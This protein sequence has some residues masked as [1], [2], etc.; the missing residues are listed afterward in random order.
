[1]EIQL[2]GQKLRV[3]VI[4][5][6]IVL[7]YIIGGHIL[8][9]CSK[10]SIKEGLSLLGYPI[11]HHMGEDVNSSWEYSDLKYN[12]TNDLYKTLEGYSAP[13]PSK[14]VDSGRLNLLSNN[15]I[16]PK[17]CPSSYSNGMGCHCISPEQMKYL[18]YRGGNRTF[19]TEF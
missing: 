17:C 2:F 6:S 4:I 13:E 7:G 12:D 9:S 18:N 3:E 8:C 15:K 19:P 11:S 16:D 5:I 14:W 1:M 10:I